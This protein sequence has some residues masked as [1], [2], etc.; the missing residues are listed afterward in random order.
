MSRISLVKEIVVLLEP[1]E[2]LSHVHLLPLLIASKIA[3]KFQSTSTGGDN[4][5]ALVIADPPSVL[6]RG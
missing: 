4:E 1:H 6:P 5:A 3:I 2:V